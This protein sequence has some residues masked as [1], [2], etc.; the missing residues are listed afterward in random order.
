MRLNFGRLGKLCLRLKAD[1][2]TDVNS[3]A[4]KRPNSCHDRFAV[5]QGAQ[6]N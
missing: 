6:S 5:M 1:Y 4:T 2:W 3:M